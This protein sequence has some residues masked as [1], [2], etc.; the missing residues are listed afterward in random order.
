[1]K[2][3]PGHLAEQLVTKYSDQAYHQALRLHRM[4]ESLGDLDSAQTYLEASHELK[5]N[6]YH[7]FT[8]QET[9]RIPIA[10]AAGGVLMTRETFD[11]I[12]RELERAGVNLSIERPSPA[13]QRA[14][15]DSLT[16][17]TFEG[18]AGS[19]ILELLDCLPDPEQVGPDDEDALTKLE[20][21]VRGD[22]HT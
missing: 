20:R 4:A 11:L 9:M 1:M 13:E 3:T 5:R 12:V 8:Q 21:R 18:A 10:T 14:F 15:D 2:I 17:A 19:R 22:S 6:G 7:R 16:V